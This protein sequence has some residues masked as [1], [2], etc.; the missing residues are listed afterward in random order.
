MV[1]NRKTIHSQ[2]L[3]DTQ[4][5]SGS[6]L[7]IATILLS[8]LPV[9]YTGDKFS[10]PPNFLKNMLETLQIIFVEVQGPPKITQPPPY[11]K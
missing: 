11:Y 9:I 5:M 1:Y 6:I 7:C 10:R 2:R 8:I 3:F 4:I